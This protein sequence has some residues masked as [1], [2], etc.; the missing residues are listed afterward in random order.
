MKEKLFS[1][2]RWKACTDQWT[3]FE[4]LIAGLIFTKYRN[5]SKLW[6]SNI[7]N[8]MAKLIPRCTMRVN[9]NFKE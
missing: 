4:D 3:N 7:D 8:N 6:Y 5:R 1:V 9:Y 2:Y